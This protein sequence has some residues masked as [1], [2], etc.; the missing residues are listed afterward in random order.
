MGIRMFHTEAIHGW[1]NYEGSEER[2]RHGLG[3]GIEV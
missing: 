3:Q 2:I 1:G